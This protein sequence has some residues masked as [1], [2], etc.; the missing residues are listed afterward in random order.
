[1]LKYFAIFSS[2]LVFCS[3]A[4]SQE[5]DRAK[6][7]DLGVQFLKGIH[8]P[9]QGYEGG[10]HKLG[11]A[12]L[13]GLALLESGVP[14]NDPA[15]RN[16]TELVPAQALKQVRTYELSLCL[17]FLDRLGDKV[18][19]P[20]I[21]ILGIHLLGGQSG[22]G[23]WTYSCPLVPSDEEIARLQKLFYGGRNVVPELGRLHA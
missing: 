14:G 17:M 15:V 6:A 9:K 5:N 1:M 21:Q 22:T 4:I 19:F 16:I 12:A 13:C 8:Q 18:D 3:N 20:T 7:I 11:G 10:S 23:K 2:I